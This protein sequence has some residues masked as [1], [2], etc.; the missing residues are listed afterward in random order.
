LP[1][2]DAAAVL[3]FPGGGQLSADDAAIIDHVQAIGRN[4]YNEG[5]VERDIYE[6]QADVEQGDSG[7]PLLAPDGTVAGVTFA[8]SVSQN[9]VGYALLINQV[10]PI[11]SQAQRQN[12]AVST[13]S[14]AQ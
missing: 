1:D 9:D 8:K 6:V 14:C 12:T 2:A 7:G 3:G 13:G 4:I 5:T 10:Q 11:V